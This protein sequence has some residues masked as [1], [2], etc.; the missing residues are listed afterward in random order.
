MSKTVHTVTLTITLEVV[1]TSLTRAQKQVKDTLQDAVDFEAI[2]G[3]VT[4]L[5]IK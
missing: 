4:S 1:A 5:I 3:E 2:A